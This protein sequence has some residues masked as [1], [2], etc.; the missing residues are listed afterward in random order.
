MHP[1]K[2]VLPR[3]RADALEANTQNAPG[4]TCRGQA[5]LPSPAGGRGRERPT[6]NDLP[7]PFR[8]TCDNCGKTFGT[9]LTPIKVQG[10]TFQVVCDAC[11]QL[12]AKRDG[13]PPASIEEW[14]QALRRSVPRP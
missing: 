6:Y 13:K 4:E 10:L 9:A 5:R 8:I 12:M 3:M 11:A 14:N 2:N 1:V 7:A